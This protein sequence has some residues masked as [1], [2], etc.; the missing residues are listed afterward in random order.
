MAMKTTVQQ[1]DLTSEP[2]TVVVFEEKC[3]RLYIIDDKLP[4]RVKNA[5]KRYENKES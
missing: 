3:T 5:I 4:L 1:I 2:Q